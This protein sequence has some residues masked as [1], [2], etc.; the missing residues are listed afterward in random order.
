MS[1]FSDYNVG[2]FEYNGD[3]LIMTNNNCCSYAN[4]Y[5]PRKSINHVEVGRNIPYSLIAAGS[6]L[7]STGLELEEAYAHILLIIG[8]IILAIAF[9]MSI[10]KKISIVT[11]NGRFVYTGCCE[12]HDELL[13]WIYRFGPDVE[14]VQRQSMRYTAPNGL[15]NQIDL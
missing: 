7:L 8:A 5:V 2:S 9:V 14:L 15:N 10:F 4:Y 3:V 1:I 11:N 12:T 13:Q 6:G